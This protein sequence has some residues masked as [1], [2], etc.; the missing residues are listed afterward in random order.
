MIN[1]KMKYYKQKSG[2]KKNEINILT[3]NFKWIT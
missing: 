3:E 1:E 2:R